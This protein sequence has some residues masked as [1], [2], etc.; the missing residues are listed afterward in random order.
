M[1]ANPLNSR[2]GI[3]VEGCKTILNIAEFDRYVLIDDHKLQPTEAFYPNEKF[4]LIVYC[5]T[6]WLWDRMEYTAKYVNT[7]N[8]IDAHPEAK[9]VWLG[10]GSSMY[11]GDENTYILRDT[12]S[13]IML[14]NTFSKDLVFV[15]DS[16][17][18]EILTQAGVEHHYLSCPSFHFNPV[19]QT[20]KEF[21][22]IFYHA[23]LTGISAGYWTFDKIQKYNDIFF[24]FYIQMQGSTIAI[25]EESE[26]KSAKAL[27][28]A[29][30]T[31]L[32]D[33][34]DTFN[35]CKKARKV[36]SSRIHNAVPALVYGAD[37]GI[38][39]VDSRHRTITD[40]YD[41]EI[42]SPLDLNK[43]SRQTVITEH[44]ETYR[45]LIKEFLK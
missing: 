40:W 39:P 16:L 35:I 30:P 18:H 41:I 8:L 31:L 44:K 22:V 23:P 17:A 12:P 27:F 3:I 1:G 2:D 34:I 26:W 24:E 11:L 43:I 36:L 5:G 4:D 33:P 20:S 42:N 38:V 13:Q 9:V 6:P 32:K 7:L 10:I 19:C 45:R 25:C 37:V 14:Q 29:E 15:R 21:D 28:G